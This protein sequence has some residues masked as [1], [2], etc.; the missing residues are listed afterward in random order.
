MSAEDGKFLSILSLT[1]V[2]LGWLFPSLAYG[3]TSANPFVAL[4][5]SVFGF[6]VWAVKS[7]KE[8]KMEYAQ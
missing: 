2:I 4:G 1:V 5:I 8:Y 6:V 7:R 3:S